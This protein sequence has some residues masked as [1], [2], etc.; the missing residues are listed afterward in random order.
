MSLRP[1]P[2]NPVGPTPFLSP[3]NS[4][5][6]SVWVFFPFLP[7]LPVLFIYIAIS[8]LCLLAFFVLPPLV[9][10]LYDSLVER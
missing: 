8:T 4:L 10:A 3:Q 2:R 5:S 9:L 1:N 6:V 7:L